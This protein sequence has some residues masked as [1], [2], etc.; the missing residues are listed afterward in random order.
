MGVLGN[1]LMADILWDGTLKL[2]GSGADCGTSPSR[3]HRIAGCP[4]G[5][6]GW[7]DGVRRDKALQQLL[8]AAASSVKDE[9]ETLRE[10]V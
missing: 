3:L 10:T 8:R 5:V 2:V 6:R 1:P 9:A 4:L 7:E